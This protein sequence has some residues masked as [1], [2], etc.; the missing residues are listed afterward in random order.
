MAAVVDANDNRFAVNP[1]GSIQHKGKR[2]LLGMPKRHH[3]SEREAMLREVSHHS[4]IGRREFDVDE[5][6]G[7]FSKSRS[8][9][10]LYG[11]G[12]TC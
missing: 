11:H 6:Q 4:S 9:L 7:A 1:G 5:A 10:G 8:A 12:N 3:G 2:N